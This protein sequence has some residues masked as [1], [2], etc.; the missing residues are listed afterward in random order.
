MNTPT[1]QD[2][3]LANR[4]CPL[5]DS[6][7]LTQAWK[8]TAAQLI[9]DHTASLNVYKV[10]HI[11]TIDACMWMHS[12]KRISERLHIGDDLTVEGVAELRRQ[13]EEALKALRDIASNLGRGSIHPSPCDALRGRA[14]EVLVA[15]GRQS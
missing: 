8:D 3:D 10:Q 12:D 11:K 9:A 13:W 2:I 5:S 14:S 4:L 7:P 1:P 15:I 6:L